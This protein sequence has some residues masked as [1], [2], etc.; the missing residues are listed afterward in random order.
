MTSFL[1]KMFPSLKDMQIIIKTEVTEELTGVHMSNGTAIV[2]LC[3]RHAC[4]RCMAHQFVF[5]TLQDF[6]LLSWVNVSDIHD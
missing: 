6:S 3:I 2:C 1:E 5:I 4:I